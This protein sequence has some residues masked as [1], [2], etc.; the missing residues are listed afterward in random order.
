[1]AHKN[2][3][4][5]NELVTLF[6]QGR[7]TRRR[8]IRHAAQLGLSAALVNQLASVTFAAGDDILESSPAAPNESPITRE[9]AEYLQSNP[10]KNTTIN[11]MVIRSAVG[12]C[13][14]YHAPEMGGGNGGPRQHY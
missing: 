11:V 2:S 7:M 14:E 10:Y 12:D 5:F 6:F 13:V 9:R 1:M 4:E 3:E 8:F